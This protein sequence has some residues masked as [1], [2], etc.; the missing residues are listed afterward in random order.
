MN[1]RYIQCRITELRLKKNISEYQMSMELGQKQGLYSG[2]FCREILPSMTQ[3]LRICDYFEI[4]PLQFFDSEAANPQL[5]N[6]DMEGMRTLSEVD[7]IMLIGLINRL[8]SEKR[9][10][11]IRLS[12]FRIKTVVLRKVAYKE[13]AG[14]NSPRSS[15]LV[16]PPSETGYSLP[17]LAAPVP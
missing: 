4:F 15:I 7:L 17:G 10:D 2:G 12:F 13:R 8:Q 11:V 3:F 6:R 1:A 16:T 14:R 9:A 5:F